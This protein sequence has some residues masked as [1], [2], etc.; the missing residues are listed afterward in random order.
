[1]AGEPV[2]APEVKPEEVQEFNET[3]NVLSL[4]AGRSQT[5]NSA[6]GKMSDY[7]KSVGLN[8]PADANTPATPA[9][10]ATTAQTATATPAVATTEP[11]S[12]TADIPSDEIEVQGLGKINLGLP[13]PAATPTEYKTLDDVINGLGKKWGVAAKDVNEFV[14]KAD[15]AFTSHRAAAQKAGDLEAKQKDISDTFAKM[16]D[17]LR[18]SFLAWTKGEDYKEVFKETGI[19][20]NKPADQQDPQTLVAKFFPN[21][22]TKEDFE[23]HKTT[24]NPAIEIAVQ[25]SIDKFNTDKS[26]R[27]AAARAKVDSQVAYKAQFDASVDDSVSRITDDL[28]FLTDQSA[29]ESLKGDLAHLHVLRGTAMAKEFLKEDGTLRS[30]AASRWALAKH[31]KQLLDIYAGK[32]AELA[33]SK[34]TEKVVSKG[35]DTPSQN[36]GHNVNA[37]SQTIEQKKV[38]KINTT[39]KPKKSVYS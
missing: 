20:Y 19:N 33:A 12:V 36:G 11:V 24:P 10:T 15:K 18:N 6:L 25:A 21:K 14:D 39:F 34:A 26:S 5:A 22:F 1:M 23:E 4:I 2:A 16:P 31:G 37:G 27:E 3:A 38:E 9:Q 7:A 13:K 30:D 32:V 8:K 29:I 28:P 35:A 17:D